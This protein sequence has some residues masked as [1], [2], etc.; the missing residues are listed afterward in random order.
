MQTAEIHQDIDARFWHEI[1]EHVKA[2][3]RHKL[4]AEVEKSLKFTFR[5]VWSPVPDARRITASVAWEPG[6]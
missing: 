5:E 3:M 4:M 1:S 2:S 6:R